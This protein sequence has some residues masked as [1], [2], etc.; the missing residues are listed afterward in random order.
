GAS[1]ARQN[2]LEVV[3]MQHIQLRKRNAPRPH[4]LHTGLVLVAPGIREAKPV[5]LVSERFQHRPGL[6]RDAGAPID[7]GAE[8]VEEQSL[9]G[10]RR[11][12]THECGPI[13]AWSEASPIL[14]G[15]SA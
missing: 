4:L 8:Y 7:E 3:P 2:A 15:D 13:G 14:I 11:G 1:E 6:A 12:F 5:N 10:G 9:D